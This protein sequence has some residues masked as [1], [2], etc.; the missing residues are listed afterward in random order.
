MN[1]DFDRF[2][3]FVLELSNYL[4][5]IPPYLYSLYATVIAYFIASFLNVGA[6]NSFGNW[7]EQVGQI[8]LTISAQASATPTNDE[9]QTLVDEI[10][11]L[12]QKIEM[13][14]NN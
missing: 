10:N 9:Y 8:L 1:D 2:K 13:L 6:Q 11:N 7:L 4:D 5:S 14:K 3:C 12:K